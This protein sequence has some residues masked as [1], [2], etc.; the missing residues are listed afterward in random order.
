[1]VSVILGVGRSQPLAGQ[2]LQ[3]VLS[4]GWLFWLQLSWIQRPSPPPPQIVSALIL[5]SAPS[6]PASSQAAWGRGAVKSLHPTACVLAQL[7]KRW[8][9][10]DQQR[11]LQPQLPWAGMMPVSISAR[12]AR[13]PGCIV[14]LS[15]VMAVGGFLERAKEAGKGYKND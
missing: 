7:R 8:E 6:S 4:S 2:A 9:E 12:L 3:A 1:M 14:C 13:S 11:L 15:L 5:C 10:E